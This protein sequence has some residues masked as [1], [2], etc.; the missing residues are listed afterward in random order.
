MHRVRLLVMSLCLLS[1]A[2]MAEEAEAPDMDFLE[3][4]GEWQ[5]DDEAWLDT[6]ALDDVSVDTEVQDDE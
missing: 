1:S 5:G 6:Q 2:V 3:F 4:L